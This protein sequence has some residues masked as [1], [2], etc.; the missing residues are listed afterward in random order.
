MSDLSY[1]ARRHGQ[2]GWR[3]LVFIAAAVTLTV[4]AIG[5]TT[6]KVVGKPAEHSW[7]VIVVDPDTHI[8]IR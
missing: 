8:E 4:L 2:D 7:S 5:A 1:I 3:D 6:S